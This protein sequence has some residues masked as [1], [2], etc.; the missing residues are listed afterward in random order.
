MTPELVNP[1]ELMARFRANA[2]ERLER[3]DRAWTLLVRGEGNLQD[4]NNPQDDFETEALAAA[5]D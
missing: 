1:E 3:I 4:N 2:M 5:Q